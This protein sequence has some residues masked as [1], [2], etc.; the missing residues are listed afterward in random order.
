MSR[1]CVWRL[2]A[3]RRVEVFGRDYRI[4]VTTC[5][6]FDNDGKPTRIAGMLIDVTEHKRIQERLQI[7]Q[8]AP[9]GG[10]FEYSTG[11][12]LPVLFM[13]GYAPDAKVRADFLATGM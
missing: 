4:W 5:G 12:G 10:T 13:T 6:Y 11:F 1:A 8:T 9:G 7:A 2:P 3:Q